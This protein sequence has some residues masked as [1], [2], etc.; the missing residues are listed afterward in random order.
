MKVNKIAPMNRARENFRSHKIPIEDFQMLNSN[1]FID[2]MTIIWIVINN[3]QG[4][5]SLFS[6]S[7]KSV[8]TLY[9]P[10]DM[11][12]A[13]LPHTETYQIK[14]SPTIWTRITACPRIETHL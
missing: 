11:V 2:I 6:G 1:R 10:L 3:K 14:Q 4:N 9:S 12:N 8:E 13:I 5:G 7:L